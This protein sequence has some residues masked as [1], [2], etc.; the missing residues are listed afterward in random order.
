MIWN[1]FL[2]DLNWAIDNITWRVGGKWMRGTF[3]NTRV[4]NAGKLYLRNIN[5]RMCCPRRSSRQIQWSPNKKLKG[6]YHSDHLTFRALLVTYCTY[7][8]SY[9]LMELYIPTWMC[10]FLVFW[11]LNSKYQRRICSW[12]FDGIS[13]EKLL[14]LKTWRTFVNSH[15]LSVQKPKA[16]FLLYKILAI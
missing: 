2:W 16:L 8:Y 11:S 7:M 1:H 3:S 10:T 12:G 9:S 14:G 5:R 4:L 13:Q 15:T 6:M